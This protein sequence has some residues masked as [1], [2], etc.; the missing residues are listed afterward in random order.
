MMIAELANFVALQRKCIKLSGS[1]TLPDKH[2]VFEKDLGTALEL[3]VF[4]AFDR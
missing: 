4:T 2:S 3:V 1:V